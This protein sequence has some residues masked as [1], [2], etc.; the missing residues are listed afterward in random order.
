MCVIL[1]SNFTT[2]VAQRK[3]AMKLHE[4]TPKGEMTTEK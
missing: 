1:N 4:E 3:V 2:L